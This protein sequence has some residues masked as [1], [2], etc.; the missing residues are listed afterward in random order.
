MKQNGVNISNSLGATIS[1][2]ALTPSG[3]GQGI[4]MV[5]MVLFYI[6]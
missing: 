4:A 2:L 3:V 5:V 1:V 6:R